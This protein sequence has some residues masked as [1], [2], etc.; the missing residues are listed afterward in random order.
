VFKD[1]V[2]WLIGMV[3]DTAAAETVKL[4]NGDDPQVTVTHEIEGTGFD[5]QA[6]EE[7]LRIR[8]LQSMREDLGDQYKFGIEVLPGQDSDLWD[9][10]EKIEDAF[11]DAG[12]FI[13]D[14]AQNQH[15]FCRPVTSVKPCDLG[16]MW[17]DKRNCIGH[18]FMFSERGTVIHA[19]G[20]RG[21]VEDD[22][23]RWV[24]HKRFR[25]VRRH[26]CFQRGPDAPQNGKPV[27]VPGLDD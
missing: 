8:I 15:D 19:V 10:S 2:K 12:E 24:G 1:F 16:F 21:V 11:R 6:A 4:P 7:E 20:G 23:E 22:A 5:A 26:P 17:S 13:P 9:C 25:G 18:V 3:F 27:D 14:G